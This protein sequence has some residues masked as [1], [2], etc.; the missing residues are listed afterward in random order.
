MKK[1]FISALL[2]ALVG[3][4]VSSIFF[5]NSCWGLYNCGRSPSGELVAA[6]GNPDACNRIAIGI[7]MVI[8]IIGLLIG[9]I[10]MVFSRESMRNVKRFFIRISLPIAIILFIFG[11]MFWIW[12]FA[13][14]VGCQ[15]WS[16]KA[17]LYPSSLLSSI[18]SFVLFLKIFILTRKEKDEYRTERILSKVF[19]IISI[20]IFL[21]V[22][23]LGFLTAKPGHCGPSS[24]V[25]IKADIAGLRASAELYASDKDSYEGYC[26]SWDAERAKESISANKSTLVCNANKNEYAACAQ[27]MRNGKLNSYFCSDS[28]GIS[29]EIKGSCNQDWKFTSCPR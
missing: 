22:A 26:D 5:F 6:C 7:F 4:V 15:E 29:K 20:I 1:L 23:V 8:T 27:I 13:T 2:G 17:Y 24:D 19:L 11:L 16:Y 3:L 25:S 9:G 18:I 14:S 10:L 28:T 21:F 12:E